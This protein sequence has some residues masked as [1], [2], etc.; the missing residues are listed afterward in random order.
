[1]LDCQQFKWEAVEVRC[2]V[3]VL[4][5]CWIA[6]VWLRAH[7]FFAPATASKGQIKL[8][9]AKPTTPS[10]YSLDKQTRP[11]SWLPE[12]PYCHKAKHQRWKPKAQGQPHMCMP[13]PSTGDP[14]C[15]ILYDR[16]RRYYTSTTFVMGG[17]IPYAMI[18]AHPPPPS[19]DPRPLLSVRTH[20]PMP[21]RIDIWCRHPR[22]LKHL[23]SRGDGGLELFIYVG[24]SMLQGAAC[25][26]A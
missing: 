7:L 21:H 16:M 1:M 25:S 23:G 17:E 15:R 26:G 2:L 6:T 12:A 20:L 13:M 9:H 10:I 4:V 14:L 5:K 19:N 11:T 3:D 24:D 22:Q 8:S 18:H